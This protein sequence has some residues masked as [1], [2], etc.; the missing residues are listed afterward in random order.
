MK[1]AKI[2]FLLNKYKT[3]GIHLE[4]ML[5][6]VPQLNMEVVVHL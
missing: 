1:L 5:E 3:I 4:Y 2:Y 6:S